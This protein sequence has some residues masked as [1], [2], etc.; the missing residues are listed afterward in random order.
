MA[1]AAHWQWHRKS[2]CAR[3][4][5]PLSDDAVPNSAAE[6]TQLLYGNIELK[7]IIALDNMLLA[8]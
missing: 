5:L 6:L 4:H 2:A 3:V 8:S 7:A 1:S